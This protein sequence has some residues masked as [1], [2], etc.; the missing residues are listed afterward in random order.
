MIVFCPLKI[1]GWNYEEKN[2]RVERSAVPMSIVLLELQESVL[3]NQISTEAITQFF[4]NQDAGN[5]HKRLGPFKSDRV[6]LFG[7]Q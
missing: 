1:S 6:D 3:N 5:G 4:K 7:Y 2:A